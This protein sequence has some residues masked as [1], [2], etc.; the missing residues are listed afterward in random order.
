MQTQ[1]DPPDAETEAPVPNVIELP[2]W[3]KSPLR[4]RAKISKLQHDQYPPLPDDEPKLTWE[5]WAV[6]G[7]IAGSFVAAVVMLILS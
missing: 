2:V 5:H 7:V 4:S 1:D 3:R 6:G